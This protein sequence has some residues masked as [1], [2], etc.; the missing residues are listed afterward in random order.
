[1]IN[2]DNLEYGIE[3]DLTTTSGKVYE[4][5]YLYS[6]E[7]GYFS[8]VEGDQTNGLIYAESVASI[9]ESN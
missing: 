4:G 5:W 8:R 9:R 2:T 6:L 7:C 1:M 3:Y